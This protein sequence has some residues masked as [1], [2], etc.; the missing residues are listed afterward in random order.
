M[1]YSRIARGMREQIEK[2]LGVVCRAEGKVAHR[3]VAEMVY[4]IQA[5]QSVMLSEI[6][7]SLQNLFVLALLASH[8]ACAVLALKAKLKIMTRRTLLLAKRIFG[9]P[10]FMYYAIADGI[11]T[12]FSRHPCPP[13]PPSTQQNPQLTLFNT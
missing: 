5:S 8:F 7:R 11:K 4:G 10:K 12:V 2:F 13:R 6:A 3:F 1:D 9:I